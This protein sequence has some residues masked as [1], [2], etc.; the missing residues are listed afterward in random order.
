MFYI[1]LDV[2]SKWTRIEGF[3]PDTGEVISFP[4]V[5]NEWEALQ[6]VFTNLEGPLHAAMEI[7]TNAWAMYWLLREMVDELTVVDALATWGREGRRGAK[8]DKRDARNLARK[9]AQ[10]QLQPLYVPD[11]QTQEY[12]NLIRA[13]V[14]TTRRKT[15]LVNEMGALLRSW[16]VVVSSSLLSEKGQQLIEDCRQQLP[17][18]S[19]LVLAGLEKQLASVIEQ[20][21]IFTAT[22]EK[23]VAEDEVCQ[24]LLSIPE[25]G[26]ITAF[27][28]RAEVGDIRRFP[29]A[30]QF[31]SYCG[32]APLTQQSAD[33]QRAGQ[34]P[35][36]CNKILRYLL[37]L[38]GAGMARVRRDHPLRRAY[39][40]AAL[41]GHS[42]DGHIAAA[43]KLTRIMY[44]MLLHG[45]RWQAEKAAAR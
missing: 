36:A 19:Q 26:P 35:T 25:V 31:V 42:T 44:A 33:R 27:G 7:G 45:E 4:K 30:K 40:R 41:R 22:I 12:R 5:A 34:L 29:S 24:L 6:A 14:A 32:L 28:V 20:E 16:G 10:G 38:R 8:T 23:L 13:K 11:R 18:Y 2:H 39:F 37:V 1:G 15:A 21:E 3:D 17:Q 9:L 43:R